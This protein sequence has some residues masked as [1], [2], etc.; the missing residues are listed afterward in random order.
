MSGVDLKMSGYDQ[1]EE[2]ELPLMHKTTIPVEFI[3]STCQA[4]VVFILPV[5]MAMILSSIAAILVSYPT[6]MEMEQ[7]LV[8]LPS[9][10]DSTSTKVKDAFINALV[11]IL[12]VAASTFLMVCLFKYKATKCI[13]G[14]IAFAQ[15]SILTILSSQFMNVIVIQ[16]HLHIDIASFYFIMYNFGCVGTLAVLY[17][18]G[19][20]SSLGQIYLV[21]ASILMAWQFSQFPEWTTWALLILLAFYDIW[22]VLTPYGPLNLLIGQVQSSGMTLPGLLYEASIPKQDIEVIKYETMPFVTQVENQEPF[23]DTVKLGLGDFIF[24]SVLVSRAA[25]FQFTAMVACLITVLTVSW[26]LKHTIAAGIDI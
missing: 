8:Y 9:D 19:L 23:D 3:L 4:G 1:E 2:L 5:T 13:H 16:T 14:Y 6:P 17:Q 12:T 25:M 21:I 10:T 7:Y 22:A 24:Y 20:P 11:I 15:F 26:S 18:K